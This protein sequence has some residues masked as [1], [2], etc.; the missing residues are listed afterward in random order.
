MGSYTVWNRGY[1]KPL[2]HPGLYT[3][4]DPNHS[5]LT[6]SLHATVYSD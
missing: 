3:I 1:D 5:W 4:H 2:P 6:A